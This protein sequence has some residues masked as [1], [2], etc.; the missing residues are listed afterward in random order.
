M[1]EDIESQ[2]LTFLNCNAD[3]TA[4]LPPTVGIEMRQARGGGWAT[5]KSEVGQIAANANCNGQQHVVRLDPIYKAFVQQPFV[6]GIV[7]LQGQ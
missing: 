7:A 6:L 3:S 1:M 5:Q 4:T 2:L